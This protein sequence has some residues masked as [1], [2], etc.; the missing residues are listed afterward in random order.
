MTAMVA[1]RDVGVE[2]RKRRFDAFY[3]SLH[4]EGGLAT[5][6]DTVTA[7]AILRDPDDTLY[8]SKLAHS[9]FQLS[10]I[11]NEARREGTDEQALN[12]FLSVALSAIVPNPEAIDQVRALSNNLL[13]SRRAI[14]DRL[15]KAE[16]GMKKYEMMTKLLRGLF[17]DFKTPIASLKTSTY[18][19]RKYLDMR[20]QA[21]QKFAESNP[22]LATFLTKLQT[23]AAPTPVP[24]DQQLLDRTQS[25]DLQLEYMNELL[26]NA[27]SLFQLQEGISE[28]IHKDLAALVKEVGEQLKDQ[29]EDKGLILEIS[30]PEKATIVGD[31]LQLKRML[32]NLVGNAIKYTDQGRVAVTMEVAGGKAVIAIKDTGPGMSQDDQDKLF[33]PFF[34]SARTARKQGTGLGLLVVKEIAEHHGGSIAV[35]SAL[36]QGTTFTVTLP[37]LEAA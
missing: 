36:D 12:L 33:Q 9:L 1:E 37:L 5:S 10:E 34:R 17:H 13:D 32:I 30:T 14:R 11:A 23:E 25:L 24:T 27:Q 2:E 18:L 19:V 7:L 21:S 20:M 22:Q 28:K 16:A 8:L 4:L 3:R 31:P 35:Q 26:N 15:Q 29:A 6:I